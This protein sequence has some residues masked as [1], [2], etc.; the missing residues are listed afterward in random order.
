MYTPKLDLS[1]QHQT[2]FAELVQKCLD[3]SFDADFPENG[4]FT[5]KTRNGRGYWYYN[6]YDAGEAQPRKRRQRYAGPDDDIAV[7]S[8]VDAFRTIKDNYQARLAL[9]RS[10]RSAG[11]PIA[12]RLIGDAVEAL[13]KA[14]VF[15]MRCVLVGTT[16]FQTYSGLL[17]VRLANTI[18][19]TEDIDIAQYHSLSVAVEDSVEPPVEALTAIDPTFHAVPHQSDPRAS[20]RIVNGAN[21][22]VEFLTPNDSSNDYMGRPA[23]M[24]ALGG[25]SAEP[26]RFLDYL[27]RDAVWS[28]VLHKG[29][30]PVRVPLPERYAIHKLIVS[31]RRRQDARSFA[32][33]GKDTAQAEALI[34]SMV[35]TRRSEEIG[36]AWIEAWQRGP[37]WQDALRSGRARLGESAQAGL[38]EAIRQAALALKID[39]ASVTPSA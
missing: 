17:G 5:L 2:M 9:V 26:L 38:T 11:L 33:A 31:V 36:L 35:D 34:M 19:A 24:P 16:A 30:I 8:R 13:W 6:G 14:G 23:A 29:G 39:T 25:M 20:T 32:K 28:V 1:I 18:T 10:L 15:R 37:H 4:S 21:F 12:E 22:A 7:S 3:A 27:I